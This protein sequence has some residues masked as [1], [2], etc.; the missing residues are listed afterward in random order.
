MNFVGC[1]RVFCL[2][3]IDEVCMEAAD[4]TFFGITFKDRQPIVDVH[5]DA[6]PTMH[7]L[8]LCI[9]FCSYVFIYKTFL[10]TRVVVNT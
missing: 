3:H 2:S 10:N 5:T 9:S 6:K 8:R 4:R 1:P 7:L